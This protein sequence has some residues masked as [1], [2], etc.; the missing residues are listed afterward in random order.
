ME[1]HLP[2]A[3]E[4]DKG[5]Q[6][7]SKSESPSVDQK[8]EE[9]TMSADKVRYMI[10]MI[11][12]YGIDISIWSKVSNYISFRFSRVAFSSTHPASF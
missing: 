9:R 2:R 11:Y 5:Q 8:G 4:T 1:G 10:A 12:L 7:T 3:P 6:E